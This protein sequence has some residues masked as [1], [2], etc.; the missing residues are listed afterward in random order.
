MLAGLLA[1][2]GLVVAAVSLVPPTYSAMGSVLLLPPT[3]DLTD[4]A[5]PLLQLGG[6]EQ[7]AALAVA[8]LTGDEAHQQF[9]EAYPD[10]QYDVELDTLSRGPLVVFTVE[11][12]TPDG[13][14]AALHGA[15]GLL[16]TALAT[17]QDNVDA[18]QNSWVRSTPL[19]I[20]PEASTVTAPTLRAAIAAAGVGLVLAFAGAV[21]LDSL[22]TRRAE[23][24]AQRDE[25]AGDAAPSAPV[26]PDFGDEDRK[27]VV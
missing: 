10:A 9:A 1:A 8:Y 19:S 13:V 11:A 2:A 15:V 18:P 26:Q 14:I 24:K 25:S 22:L 5:N 23:R 16:P 17:L 3:R 21:A 27:S 6:L 20:D 7:P 12:P 4:G